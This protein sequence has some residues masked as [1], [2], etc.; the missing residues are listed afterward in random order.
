MPKVFSCLHDRRAARSCT[1]ISQILR[2]WKADWTSP[3]H[4]C[5][6][7]TCISG[8]LFCLVV[9]RT[10]STFFHPSENLLESWQICTECDGT[11][12]HPATREDNFTAIHL[13]VPRSALGAFPRPAAGMRCR[14]YALPQV[15][16]AAGM[17]CRRY[18]LPQV[19][20]SHEILLNLLH[21]L[22]SP[23]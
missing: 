3:W 13:G 20:A 4:L 1:E 7:M 9:T 21:H 23:L 12:M 15:C 8:R 14:R 10:H 11:V 17:R 5:S 19:C 22:Y 2:S 6:V 16:A 18:A